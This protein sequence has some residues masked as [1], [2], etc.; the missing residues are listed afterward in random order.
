[1]KLLGQTAVVTG[2]GRNVGREV[3][4]VFAAEGANVVVVDADEGRARSVAGEVEAVRSGC[5]L[6]VVCDVSR[7]DEV[8]RMVAEAVGSFGRID[9]LVNNVAITDR[10]HTVLDLPEEEWRRVIDVGLTTVFLCTKYVAGQMVAQGDGGRIINLGS[11]SAYRGRSNAT[12]YPAVKG[13]VLSL[14]RSLAVQLGPYGIRVNTLLPNKVGSPV[15]KDVEPE[16]R[17]RSNLLGR[18]ARPAD[19]AKAALFLACDDS[20]FVTATELL[21]D[22]GAMAVGG[23]A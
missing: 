8:R 20:D 22:G 7:S 17:G 9:V 10:G 16:D 12:A 11:T 4:L 2:A 6:A 19:V 14:T 15:G 1:M 21:V 23:V 3:A 13:A 5:A 18:G